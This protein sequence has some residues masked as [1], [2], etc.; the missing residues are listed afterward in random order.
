MWKKIVQ[1]FTHNNLAKIYSEYSKGEIFYTS[2]YGWIIFDKNTKTWSFNND[3]VSLVYPIS[4]FFCHTMKEY[5]SYFY[6]KNNNC[7]KSKQEEE[8]FLKELKKIEKIKS[9]VGDSGFI[10]GVINKFNL[11]LLSLMNF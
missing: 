2:G 1:D 8:N 6:N 3:K 10:S 7:K 5:S 11:Y 9:K 4:S